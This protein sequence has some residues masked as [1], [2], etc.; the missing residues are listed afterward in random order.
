MTTNADALFSDA[1]INSV[2]EWLGSS[3]I[4]EHDVSTGLNWV[5]FNATVKQ[6]EELLKAKY[7]IFQHET[8]ALHIACD[9]YSVPAHIQKDVDLILPTVHFDQ[10]L[11][12]D[13][14]NSL[15]KR[16]VKPAVKPGVAKG[17]G[18][19]NNGFLPKKGASFAS[20]K[21]IWQQLENCDKYIVPNCLRALYEFPPGFT[22][23]KN[24]SYGIVEYTT[25]AYVPSDLDLWFKNFSS[26]QV[27][28]RPIL[29]SL[30][31]GYA[32]QDLKGFGYNGES[33]LD[34]EYAM[35]LVYPQ[36]VTLFQ[37]GDVPEGASFNDF[38]DGIDKSYC[39][40]DGGDDPVQ[41]GTYPDP[42][43]GGYQGAKDC[44]KYAPS[45]VISTSY[46]YN[47]AD[48]TPFYER[49]QC[50]EYLKLGLLGTSIL[51]S[52]GDYGVAGNL[53][54]C[55]D[56]TTGQYNDGTSG[57]FNPSFPATCPY[58]TAVGATQVKN[59][60]NIIK[61]LASKTQPEMACE[62]VIYSGGGFS[63]VFRLPAYQ[64]K[65]VKSYFAKYK[66][67]YSATQ[68]NNS[69]LTRGFPDVS[70]NGANYIITVQ[71][72]FSLVYGTSASSPT[73]GSI[74]TLIN[75]AR[76][77]AGK[78]SVG[79]INPFIYAY[80]Q[81]FNDITEGGNQGCGTPGFSAVPGWDP[82]TGL[83]TPNFPKLLQY[84]LALP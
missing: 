16:S 13:P 19:P 41:D 23:N 7:S 12:D 20:F 75:E 5:N 42:L 10:R 27:G 60:T 48:L 72:N 37:V 49:R 56:P 40:Y 24:N 74:L 55:I 31:G 45:K 83:G 34:L 22:K 68:Y 54:Q 65:A 26:K 79:F 47:E 78:S 1:T 9:S 76:L 77:F 33:N 67:T 71:G 44:G 8:G 64:S 63:N 18:S 82:V 6:A 39:T 17:V 14:E 15:L 61:A 46:G 29:N 70:A 35:A 53:G 36:N 52:S 50:R 62:T 28:N 25:Q 66:P 11:R 43:P 30:D 58:V 51:Y 38:L 73:F 57:V 69:M 59:N 81:A 2:R 3:G 21:Q 84:A 32:Q 80:P 4:S